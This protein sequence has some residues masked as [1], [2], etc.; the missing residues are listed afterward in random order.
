MRIAMRSTL[1]ASKKEPLGEVAARVRQAFLDAGLGEP[2]IRF[3]FCDSFLP[4]SVSA[5]DRVLKRHPDMEEISG[6]ESITRLHTLSRAGL[7]M[8]P[9]VSLWNTRRSRRSHPVSPGL[10]RFAWWRCISIRRP[11]AKRCVA[12]FPNLE[13]R[14]PACW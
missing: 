11:L 6:G 14:C 2:A 9:P 8:S 4:D 1:A 10:T 13:L 7:Q 12:R 5:V 3:T